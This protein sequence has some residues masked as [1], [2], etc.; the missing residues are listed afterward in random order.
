MT[1]VNIKPVSFNVTAKSVLASLVAFDKA[2]LKEGGKQ[3]IAMQ[4]YIDAWFIENGKT[5]ESC[6]SMGKTMRDSEV[7]VNLKAVEAAQGI[8]NDTRTM[9][10]YA[11][12]NNYITGAKRA[13]YF[14]VAW[15]AALFTNP[16]F[17]I[18]GGKVS[19]PKDKKAG[20]VSTT[21]I[22]AAHKTMQK[23]I[24]QYRLLNQSMLV[25]AML[26]AV[27]EFYPDFKESDNTATV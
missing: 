16:D 19:T 18:P 24:A 5:V 6:D 7:M 3:T 14:G 21:T 8:G 20:E 10:R 26:D 1:I 23:A 15:S 25:A 17:K 12:L 22:D 9:S 27:Q 2:A 13:L 11:T 4:Q